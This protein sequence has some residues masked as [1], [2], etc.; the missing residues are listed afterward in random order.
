MRKIY[1]TNL[2]ES[3][4]E[5][6]LAIIGDKRKRNHTLKEI[7]DAILYLL[8]TG[9]QWRMLPSEF[10]DWRLVYYYFSKWRD[11]GVFDQ[12][13]RELHGKIRKQR[14][15]APSPSVGIIDSQSVKTTRVGGQE[16][17]WDGGKKIKGRKRHIVVDTQGYLLSVKVH[18]ANRHDSKMGFEV[19]E[20]M[21]YDFSRMKKIYADGGYR[22][23]LIENVNDKLGYE[24]EI[25]LRS[26]KGTEFKPLPK[27][28]I[29]ER[30]FSWFE[31]FRRLAK[32][33]EYC[34]KSSEAMITL[35]F[36]AIM[37]NNIIFK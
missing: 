13:N 35:A 22:G 34:I 19:L 11:E 2:T 7:F 20:A 36:I 21:K 30:T 18:T 28:W 9:C 1:S 16:R 33:Y 6:I 17:G 26:D 31:N 23:E 12:I 3:Q 24:M 4:Y 8:K 15:R 37:L 5:A 27:R 10:P 32:D 25:T 29:V 14:G